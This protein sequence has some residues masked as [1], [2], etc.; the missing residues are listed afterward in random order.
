MRYLILILLA[1]VAFTAELPADVK[2]CVESYNSDIAKVY[3]PYKAAASKASVKLDADLKK[4]Q[5]K[6]TKNG[7]LDGATNIK[8]LR[9]QVQKEELLY[10]AE[11]KARYTIA[12]ANFQANARIPVRLISASWE[13]T[14]GTIKKKD[15]TALVSKYFDKKANTIR[16]LVGRDQFGF[17]EGGSE[18]VLKVVYT[19]GADPITI[20]FKDGCGE[21][22]VPKPPEEEK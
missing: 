21:M 8:N 20:I 6:Y 9:D 15:V 17:F 18:C 14:K 11:A 1:A 16:G 10:D 19:Q 3:A 13:T 12:Q 22:V 5:E 2:A 7:D 4:L